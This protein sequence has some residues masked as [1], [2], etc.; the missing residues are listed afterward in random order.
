LKVTHCA[1]A[2][3]GDVAWALHERD[4]DAAAL[5][6]RRTAFFRATFVPSLASALD[7]CAEPL[8]RSAFSDRLE[9]GLRQCLVDHC[10]PAVNFAASLPLDKLV[11]GLRRIWLTPSQ[12]RER[13]GP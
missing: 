4:R 10:A 11:Q 5:V 12:S 3:I 9:A 8:A 2:P 6:A 13:C 7:R 1:V